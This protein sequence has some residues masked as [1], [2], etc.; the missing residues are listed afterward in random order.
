MLGLLVPVMLAVQEL[1]GILVVCASL[2]PRKLLWRPTFSSR[3]AR[4]ETCLISTAMLLVVALVILLHC[5]VLLLGSVLSL[6]SPLHE[7][8]QAWQGSIQINYAAPL[9]IRLR[10][11]VHS[12]LSLLLTVMLRLL[13]DA[14][15]MLLTIRSWLLL[16]LHRHRCPWLRRVLLP[17]HHG[18]YPSQ[19]PR[20]GTG[21]SL[22]SLQL[23]QL[24]QFRQ[25]VRLL[26]QA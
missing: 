24:G 23:P 21:T 4:L 7:L 15:L 17:L 19:C 5:P 1:V 13:F 12:R 25:L 2:W 11:L 20:L 8:S 18:H 6:T 26:G 9:A 3:L 22:W 10:L 16:S 14:G